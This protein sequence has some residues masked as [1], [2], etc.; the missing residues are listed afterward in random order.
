[1][2]KD[3]LEGIV[4]EMRA[5]LAQ[6]SRL[7]VLL[8]NADARI[9]VWALEEVVRTMPTWEVTIPGEPVAVVGQT[10]ASGSVVEA[11]VVQS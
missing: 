6:D 3:R 11:K 10:T 8:S 7:G 2:K 9:V 4:A 1:M 5:K